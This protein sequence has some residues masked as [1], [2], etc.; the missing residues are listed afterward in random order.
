MQPTTITSPTLGGPA[1]IADRHMHM[2][3]GEIASLPRAMR[4]DL[5]IAM[6]TV[7][8]GDLDDATIRQIRAASDDFLNRRIRR[9][10]ADYAMERD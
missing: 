2:S 1:S 4:E 3:E 9:L 5:M 8:T 7:L 6:G 10:Q